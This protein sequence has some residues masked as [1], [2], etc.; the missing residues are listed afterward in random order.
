MRRV[1]ASFPRCNQRVGSA[2][3]SGLHAQ[4]LQVHAMRS[5]K[6][7]VVLVLASAMFFAACGDGG[8]SDGDGFNDG[9]GD[10][11]DDGD[12]AGEGDNGTCS[13]GVSP[14]TLEYM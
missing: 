5:S 14:G 11:A 9:D 6:V 10:D 2:D 3:L 12:G 8:D 13:A 1:W 7:C 4:A